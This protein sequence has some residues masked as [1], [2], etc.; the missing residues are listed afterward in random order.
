MEAPSIQRRILVPVVLALLPALVVLLALGIAQWDNE[1]SELESRQRLVAQAAADREAAFVDQARHLSLA[2]SL[3]PWA[4]CP[5]DLATLASEFPDFTGAGILGDDGTAACTWGTPPGDV[6]L[7]AAWPRIRS[8]QGFGIADFGTAGQDLV[9]LHAVGEHMAYAVTAPERFTQVLVADGLLDGAVFLIDETGLVLGASTPWQDLVGAWIY[10]EPTAV[11]GV[12]EGRGFFEA[13]G[14]LPRGTWMWSSSVLDDATEAPVHIVTGIDP[15]EGR[16]AAATVMRIN[17]LGAVGLVLGTA[18]VANIAIH[19]YV[20]KP[21]K[22]LAQRVARVDPMGPVEPPMASGVAEMDAL[23]G[24]LHRAQV[25]IH[26]QLAARTR[27]QEELQRTNRE[28]EEF[29]FVASHDL[30]EPI[31]KV[32]SF[33]EILAEECAEGLDGEARMLIERSLANA[34]RSQDLI[35]ELLD[36]SRIDRP[37]LAREVDM[38]GLASDIV[39]ELHSDHEIRVDALPPVIASPIQ[40]RQIWHNLIENAVK[41]GRSPIHVGHDGSYFVRDHGDGIDP[42]HRDKAFQMFQ[43]LHGHEVQGTGI[44][45][46]AVKKV[47]ERHG[48]RIWIEETPGG[49]A[50]FRFTLET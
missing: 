47:I 46:A 8:T 45:L 18:I 20:A 10:P 43:R 1:L 24:A 6:H 37:D 40:M 44:G 7:G 12:L 3:L 14:L 23:T 13:S 32:V 31:R 26:E 15:T 9:F 29:A 5:K 25:E 38:H 30:Q 16:A 11:T 48:G 28:L 34:R 27:Q 50:T 17:I 49:G 2:A 33:N 35:R 19:R 36:F 22:A 39:A 21:V 4:S 41:Y 42:T